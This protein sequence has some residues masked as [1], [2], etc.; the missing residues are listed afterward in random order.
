[1]ELIEIAHL[2]HEH[3]QA[4]LDSDDQRIIADIVAE[5]HPQI[6]QL[7]AGL[8]DPL[9]GARVVS[10]AVFDDHAETVTQYWSPAAAVSVK[11]RWEDRGQGRPQIVAAAPV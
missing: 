10:A 11:V 3:G 4:V 7:T 2:A 1:M 9:T 8:P 6:P 5:L